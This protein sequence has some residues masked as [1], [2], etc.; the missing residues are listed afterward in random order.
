M[1]K[2]ILTTFEAARYCHVHPGT[3]KN[4]IKNEHLKAFK[5]PGGHR[6]IH[7]RDL[8]QFLREND[9]PFIHESKTHRLRVLLIESDSRERENIVREL[10]RRTELFETISAGDAFEGG[11]L[12]ASFKPDLVVLDSEL[13]GVDTEEI[14]RRIKSSPQVEDVRVLMLSGSPEHKK[15]SGRG[16]DQY[17]VKPVD[18]ENLCREIVRFLTTKKA[19]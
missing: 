8:D 17:F 10:Q 13:P 15:P 6:R 11:E 4:W 7:R 14:A 19:R 9:I 1:A 3:I 18:P 5:T 16:V 12:L 2:E